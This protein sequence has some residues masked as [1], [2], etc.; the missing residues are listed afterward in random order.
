MILLWDTVAQER[1]LPQAL[2][3]WT[4]TDIMGLLGLADKKEI[5]SD[6]YRHGMFTAGY[7][8]VREMSLLGPGYYSLREVTLRALGVPL[9]SHSI[10]ITLAGELGLVGALVGLFGAFV[11]VRCILLNRRLFRASGSRSGQQF[12]FALTLSVAIGLLGALGRHQLANVPLWLL[13]ACVLT[14]WQLLL[15][16]DAS[17]RSTSNDRGGVRDAAIRGSKC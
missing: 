7:E 17:V 12:Y 8:L 13:S 9:D 3:R 4:E 14:P 11:A 2:E 6:Y 5:K 1:H 15:Y 16:A 10:V